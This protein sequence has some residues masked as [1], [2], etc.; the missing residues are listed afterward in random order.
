M[1]GIIAAILAV[2]PFQTTDERFE[3]TQV[4]MG[5]ATRL[6]VVAD[7]REKAEHAACAA[8]ARIEFLE[9][10][11]SDYRPTSEISRLS[12]SA[13]GDFMPIH[14]ETALLL[15]KAERVREQSLGL[16]DV[17][18]GPLVALWR[19]SRDSGVLPTF[20]EVSAARAQVDGRL[21]QLR[22]NGGEYEARL[23]K[24][25]M[26]IDFGGIA[27][28]YACDEAMRLLI[29]NGVTSGLI[30]MGGDIAVRG[31]PPGAT[32][33]NIYVP[34]LR[35]ELVLSDCAI[36][37]SGDTEQFVEIGGRRYGHIVDL[38]TGLG[39][40]QLVQATVI[41]PLGLDSDPWATALCAG[42]PTLAARARRILPPGS[43][44]ELRIT[45]SRRAQTR[46]R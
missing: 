36:S 25:G 19:R 4:H 45:S 6:V 13:G 20:E 16:F 39:T 7:S 22:T 21:V 9:E 44:V 8:F 29:A 26:R 23:V 41:T 2:A 14:Q 17:T 30:E 27:K 33:W 24:P 18:A 10:L 15:Q 32:G 40:V 42:G 37:T 3:F 35:K 43:R 38:R 5:V 1:L 31:A 34:S 11:F 12:A 28:G 46:L